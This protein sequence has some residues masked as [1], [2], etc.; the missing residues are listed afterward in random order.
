MTHAR[1]LTRY[2]CLA[3]LIAGLLVAVPSLTHAQGFPP[4][5]PYHIDTA[6]ARIMQKYATSAVERMGE[7]Q[8][9]VRARVRHSGLPGNVTRYT[10]VG[11]YIPAS[12]VRM[13][14][15]AALGRGVMHPGL[16]VAILAAGWAWSQSQG[17]HQ[18]YV[19]EE[20][21]FE[22]QEGISWSAPFCSGERF[23][24]AGAA[25]SCFRSSQPGIHKFRDFTSPTSTYPAGTMRVHYRCD[26]DGSGC[27]SASMISSSYP[28]T[29]DTYSS[30]D[31]LNESVPESDYAQLD[32][33]IP[34]ELVNQLWQSR[35]QDHQDWLQDIGYWSKSG[36]DLSSEAGRDLSKVSSESGTTAEVM[37]KAAEQNEN[38]YA[39]LTGEEEPNTETETDARTADDEQLDRWDEP[40][41]EFPEEEPEWQVEVID[42][43]PSFSFGLGSGS[44]PAPVTI[45][46]PLGGSFTIEFQKLCDLASMIRG[47]VIAICMILALY[48]VLGTRATTS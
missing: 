11:T 12:K 9:E 34:H 44:C 2:A 30:P 14:A 6:R 24:S 31:S 3:G 48:I 18:P 17:I 26:P 22:S 41:P 20:G 7:R 45:P 28:P 47:A 36:S 1:T 23:V 42:S 16:Q 21:L 13:G 40:I 10:T 38:L 25:W 8:I 33:H 39:Q 43:L 15:M 32:Q 27:L 35:W 19:D 4:G 46:H 29:T 37:K 5:H